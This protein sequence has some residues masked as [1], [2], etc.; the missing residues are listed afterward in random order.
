M[1]NSQLI[2]E[3][4][5]V[6]QVSRVVDQH[7]NDLTIQTKRLRL[8]IVDQHRKSRRVADL[9]AGFILGMQHDGLFRLHVAI[10]AL[11]T[12]DDDTDPALALRSQGDH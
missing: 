6:S 1:H 12:I 3:V 7:G 11:A 4:T 8:L 10:E 5:P 2:G 9:H